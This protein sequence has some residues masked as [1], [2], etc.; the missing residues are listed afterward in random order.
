MNRIEGSLADAML[1]RTSGQRWT[2][3]SD[4]SW[5]AAMEKAALQSWFGQGDV[6]FGA[7]LAHSARPGD[8]PDPQAMQQP[9]TSMSSASPVFA[10][11]PQPVAID[12]QNSP[13]LSVYGRALDVAPMSFR[14][15]DEEKPVAEAAALNE[16]DQEQFERLSGMLATPAD[17][18]IDALTEIVAAS[19]PAHTRSP[20]KRA[21]H[22][23]P[24]DD[25]GTAVWI[26]DASIVPANHED[27][28]RGVKQWAH[29]HGV[30][31]AEVHINGQCVHRAGTNPVRDTGVALQGR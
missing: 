28:V 12:P 27:I 5:H 3:T 11:L 9:M 8:A 31:I 10:A 18:P 16:I 2:F 19:G 1:A 24:T 21:I 20:R 17:I 30:A 6:L 29:E 4:Q 22:A 14:T 15:S 23:S 13:V 25:G 26:R 7:P